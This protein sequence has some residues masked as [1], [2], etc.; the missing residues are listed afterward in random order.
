MSI[1]TIGFGGGRAALPKVSYP[2]ALD[3]FI[4]ICFAFVFG[5]IVEYA[6]INFLDKVTTDIKR[7]LEERKKKKDST[8]DIK[9]NLWTQSTATLGMVSITL[10]YI[11]LKNYSEISN[12]WLVKK[13]LIT[14]EYVRK[15]Q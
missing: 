13:I 4:I 11:I 7:I 8:A 9:V 2:T 1:T 12:S 6:V 15:M 5:A 14:E 10:M 3:W